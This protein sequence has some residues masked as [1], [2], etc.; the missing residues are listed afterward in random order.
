MSS[1]LAFEARITKRKFETQLISMI[2]P[3]NLSA[4]P[5]QENIMDENGIPTV[6]HMTLYYKKN[7][8]HV[9]TWQ[10]GKGWVFQ[11]AVRTTA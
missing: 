2:G 7:N 10:K 4:T 1:K 3:E 6:V 11:S 8:V 5:Y 9:G